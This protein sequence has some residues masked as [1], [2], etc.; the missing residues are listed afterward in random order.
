[1]AEPIVDRQRLLQHRDLADHNTYN[2]FSRVIGPENPHILAVASHLGAT[3]VISTI[4]KAL[5]KEI[6]LTVIAHKDFAYAFED[7]E[8]RLNRVM[9]NTPAEIL[10]E[11]KPHVGLAGFSTEPNAELAMTVGAENPTVWIQDYPAGITPYYQ[12]TL[13]LRPE[14][15]PD[16]VFTAGAFGAAEEKLKNALFNESSSSYNP[17]KVQVEMTGNPYLDR[18]TRWDIPGTRSKVRQNLGVPS[19]GRLLYYTAVPGESSPE[20]LRWFAEASA[21]TGGEKD[22]MMYG[23]HPRETRNKTP[24]EIAKRLAAYS[25]A[26]RL[27][28]NGLIDVSDFKPEE[29]GLA[30]GKTD[31]L[32]MAS[33]I[34]NTTISSTGAD[35]VYGGI[36]SIHSFGELLK[37]TEV[38]DFEAPPEVALGASIAV[39]SS[40]GM[41]DAM[42]SF[43]DSS[44]R[45]GLARKMEN[46]KP[47]PGATQRVVDRLMEIAEGYRNR[48]A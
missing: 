26:A 46:F 41:L 37:G 20:G 42:R 28:P 32:I 44:F 14:W 21:R 2:L 40:E 12:K 34:V 6:N 48:L 24:E 13:G 22:W 17:N 11:A 27:L 1:M 35:A 4:T 3:N 8:M 31:A 23:R 47:T 16:Y 7:P 15:A 36:A 30:F 38:P 39:H 18:F 9:K 10:R 19:D 25:D 33:D 29:L 5:P 43:S 45:E